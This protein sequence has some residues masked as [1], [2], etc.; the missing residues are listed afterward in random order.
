M[1]RG[2]ALVDNRRRCGRPSR[3]GLGMR[4]DELFADLEGQLEHELS[5]EERGVERE[6]ERL[7]RARLTLCERLRDLSRGGRRIRV[8]LVGGAVLDLRVESAGADWVAGAAS[9]GERAR[10]VILPVA[11]VVSA[12]P[13]EGPVTGAEPLPPDGLAQ[14]LGIAFVL[15]DLGRRR[16]SVELHTAS[17]VHHGVIGRVGADHLDLREDDPSLGRG[18]RVIPFSALFVVWI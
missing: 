1:H 4:W 7:R 11:S 16:V 18:Q 15:R 2:V 14:R 8:Q 3:Y 17:G 6:A 13:V 9:R 10:D 5:V 12:V